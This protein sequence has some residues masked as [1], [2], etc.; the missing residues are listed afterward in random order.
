MQ[1]IFDLFN[2]AFFAP[3]I[4][5]LVFI[6]RLLEA[7][8][9]PGALGFGIVILTVLIKLVLWPLMSKQLNLAKKMS[10]LKPHLEELKKK[11]KDD[12]QAYAAS[13]M[14]LYKE[15]GI[16]PAGG[17]LP[18]IAQIII[19]LALYQGISALFDPNGLSRI[20]EVL[21]F[22]D[23]KLTSPPSPNFL[24]LDLSVKPSDFSR[25]GFAIM[26]LPFITAAVTFVQSKMMILSV[27]KYP[28]DSPKEKKEKTSAEDAMSSVQSQMVYLMPV[29][30]GY[31]AF[32][33]PAGL[34]IY[35][36]V[37]TILNIFQQYKISGWGGMAPLLQRIKPVK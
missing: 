31:F 4:N 3:V 11:H 27:K 20:N 16:N 19:T 17:C 35:W 37:F 15:H 18:T 34:S 24:G 30:I 13:Q 28:S 32:S 23:W 2:L 33:F 1:I 14:A 10:D 7:S 12:K 29:M 36:I 22:Q 25:A 9:I 5:L 6:I 26:V 21:Y 8:H